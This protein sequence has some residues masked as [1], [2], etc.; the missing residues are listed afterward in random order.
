MPE[1]LRELNPGLSL[2]DVFD[3]RFEKYGRVLDI[4]DASALHAALA[5]MSIPEQGNSYTASSETLER[6]P[7][8]ERIRR[9][10]GGMDIQAGCCCGQGRTLNA[11][12][13]HKCSEVNFSTTGLVLLLA[14]PEDMHDG[15][16]SSDKVVGFYLPPDTA[17][18]V[19]PRVL[20]FAPCRVSDKG[21]DC[22]VVLENG[23]NTPIDLS[24]ITPLG[25]DKLLW[26]R[27]KWLTCHPDSPQAEKGAF[28]GISG[29]NIKLRIK[30]A[31]E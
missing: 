15:F 27:G 16:I 13:Y 10:F 14:L 24:E 25:E 21:F 20:H 23:V 31:E 19:Y 26:M 29:K 11:L 17:I 9:V 2:Y 1:K 4:G 8:I 28:T 18:E 30:E 22:L 6:A 5:G 3:E 12:E 7:E